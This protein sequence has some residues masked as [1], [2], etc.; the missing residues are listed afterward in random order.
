MKI[1]EP[2]RPVGEVNEHRSALTTALVTAMAVLIA[3]GGWLVLD[4]RASVERRDVGWA[5]VSSHQRAMN[6]HD[7]DAALADL[8]P[9]ATYSEAGRTQP[10][11]NYVESMASTD[12]L[13]IATEEFTG[14]PEWIGDRQVA[15]PVHQFFDYHDEGENHLEFTGVKVITLDEVDGEL[16]ITAIEWT[17]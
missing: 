16:M 6:D 5:L 15:V 2:T 17:N 10:A 7:L 1:R 4:H 14:D 3:V 12:D 11:A 8:S 9:T 13:W